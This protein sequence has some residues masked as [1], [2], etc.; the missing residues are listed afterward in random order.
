MCILR[1]VASRNLEFLNTNPE[2]VFVLFLKESRRVLLIFLGIQTPVNTLV[3]RN[4]K[5]LHTWSGLSWTYNVYFSYLTSID[6]AS[7]ANSLQN[8]LKHP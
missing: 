6:H 3:A 8:I 1:P 5:I 7:F 4:N 2:E